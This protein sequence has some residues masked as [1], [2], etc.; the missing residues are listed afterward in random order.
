M[1]KEMNDWFDVEKRPVG[2]IVGGWGKRKRSD[3]ARAKAPRA[4][5]NTTRPTGPGRRPLRADAELDPDQD[6]ALRTPS[7]AS[8][9]FWPSTCARSRMAW[10]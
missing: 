3:S 4:E 5:V 1:E 6:Y 8:T 7:A 10:R 2:A 9:S